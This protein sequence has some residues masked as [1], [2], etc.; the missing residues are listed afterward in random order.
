[1]VSDRRASGAVVVLD[2]GRYIE[3]FGP[4]S[5]RGQKGRSPRCPTRLHEF[6]SLIRPEL[7]SHTENCPGLGNV[8]DQDERITTSQLLLTQEDIIESFLDENNRHNQC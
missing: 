5:L 8:C 7:K 1:M 4:G 6:L 3:R 2:A